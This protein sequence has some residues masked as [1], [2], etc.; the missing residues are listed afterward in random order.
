MTAGWWTGFR[1][2]LT[3]SIGAN[4][5]K[6]NLARL[7]V[8]LRAAVN[9]DCLRIAVYDHLLQQFPLGRLPDCL[10]ED[11]AA[12]HEPTGMQFVG[13]GC[14]AFG[15]SA[16]STGKRKLQ[17]HYVHRR[18]GLDLESRNP[19]LAVVFKRRIDGRRKIALGRH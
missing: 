12:R 8:D 4:D 1:G 15:R 13:G 9:N 10:F 3:R 6:R 2:E 18:T 16:D 5:S 11:L 19:Q 17:V 7:H 14:L